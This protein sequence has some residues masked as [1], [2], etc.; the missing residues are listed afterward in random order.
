MFNKD[1]LHKRTKKPRVR[2]E[3]FRLHSGSAAQAG[4]SLHPTSMFIPTFIKYNYLI[5]RDGW[6]TP[7]PSLLEGVGIYTAACAA[8]TLIHYTPPPFNVY[9]ISLQSSS[10]QALPLGFSFHFSHFLGGAGFDTHQ[11]NRK[12]WRFS[13]PFWQHIKECSMVRMFQQ[14]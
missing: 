14:M 12:A 9:T 4:C 13:A 11:Q 2:A 6:L 7:I 10:C 3:F 8:Y 5:L 1:E